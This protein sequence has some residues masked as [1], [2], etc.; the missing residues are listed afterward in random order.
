MLQ[1]LE[2]ELRNVFDDVITNMEELPTVG[3]ANDEP[4][5]TKG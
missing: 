5:A 4:A 2:T 1:P 3:V